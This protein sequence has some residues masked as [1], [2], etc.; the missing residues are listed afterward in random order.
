[1]EPRRDIQRVEPDGRKVEQRIDG[2]LVREAVTH[3]D[4][5]GELVEIF[6][7]AWGFTDFPMVYAYVTT[8]RPAKVKGWLLHRIQ[9]D[10]LFPCMGSLRIV[11]YDARPGSATNG[12]LNE[13][14]FGERRR[15]MIVIP[16]GV[17][18]ALQNVGTDE[19]L[20]FNL[21]SEPYNHSNPDKYRLPLDTDQIPFSDW[22]GP[23]W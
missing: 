20:F 12:M 4:E 1:M 6:N 3:L 7:P 11:L 19:G 2:V 16:P 14:V 18:H 15:A 22:T 13:F 21:P 9:T 8:V 10:R 5:R 17:F 23:G